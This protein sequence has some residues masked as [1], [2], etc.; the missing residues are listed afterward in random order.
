MREVALNTDFV[1]LHTE[2]A[3]TDCSRHIHVFKVHGD[4]VDNQQSILRSTTVVPG[5]NLFLNLL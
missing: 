5:F 4:R 1:R 2:N 3:W